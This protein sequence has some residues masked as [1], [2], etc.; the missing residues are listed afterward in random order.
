MAYACDVAYC[1]NKEVVF[2]YLRDRAALGVRSP[3]QLQFDRLCG[4]YASRQQPL[5]RGLHS[6][7][8][9]EA[10]SV[11]ID[12]TR[13]PLI[14]SR[15][16]DDESDMDFVSDALR[17]AGNLTAGR[18]YTFDASA[19][20]IELTDAGKGRLC[21][22]AEV[23]GG[24]WARTR[25]R[26]QLVAQ[27]IAAR[28][29]YARDVDYLVRADE[30]QLID[31][32]TGRVTPGRTW[33]QGLHQMIEAKEGVTVT[34]EPETLARISYQRF[35]RRYLRLAGLTGTAQE[36][37]RELWSVY[38]LRVATIGPHKPTQRSR[39]AEQVLATDDA[40]WQRVVERVATVHA[41][42]QPLLV[43]TASVAA[44][45]RLSALLTAA[46]L[47]HEVLNARQDHAEAEIVAGAGQRGR[48]TVATNM[49][50]RGT[51]IRLGT[52]VAELG[53]LHVI[54]SER[55]DAAR[56]DRQL[57]GRCARQ[58]DPGSFELVLSLEDPLLERAGGAYSTRLLRSLAS[59]SLNFGSWTAAAF[60]RAAQRRK[61]RAHG[62]TRARLLRA[63]HQIDDRLA[64]AGPAE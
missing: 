40:K 21:T 13:T 37:A 39:L 3:V 53:G 29:L 9:D 32:H 26:E 10:D 44:S 43:G 18:D 54:V 12:E 24:I 25:W 19:R 35:F 47:P 1:C 51:D 58:G 42:G 22:A 20:R 64:F 62:R 31:E 60:L 28:D 7:I 41:T 23:L 34:R 2:D 17:L 4:R 8:V 50:G 6:A 55:H 59:W 49:A 33:S 56:I 11:L 38:G 30:V 15:S 16:G 61:Q 48:I 27:A 57:I 45:E 46:G 63:D 52:G 14:L 36:A 5:L